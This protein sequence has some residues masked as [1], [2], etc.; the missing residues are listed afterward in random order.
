MLGLELEYRGRGLLFDKSDKSHLCDIFIEI[1][2]SIKYNNQYTKSLNSHIIIFRIIMYGRHPCPKRGLINHCETIGGEWSRLRPQK[3]RFTVLPGWLLYIIYIIH[4]SLV[5]LYS[6]AIPFIT[7]IARS[8][9]QGIDWLPHPYL[10][11]MCVAIWFWTQPC[12]SL[13]V[14][15]LVHIHHIRILFQFDINCQSYLLKIDI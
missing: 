3:K 11:H 15:I 4:N 12:L 13:C 2:P 10:Y 1:I 5:N 9:L 7:L 8:F 6:L 14:H